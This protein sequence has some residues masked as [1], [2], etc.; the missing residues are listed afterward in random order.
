MGG[1]GCMCVRE[2]QV[3]GPCMGLAHAP[4][5]IPGKKSFMYRNMLEVPQGQEVSQVNCLHPGSVLRQCEPS[6][7]TLVATPSPRVLPPPSANSSGLLVLC[8]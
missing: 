8:L 5:H 6:D 3:H 4:L 2:R 1:G 7:L